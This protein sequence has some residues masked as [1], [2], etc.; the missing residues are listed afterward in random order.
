[1]GEEYGEIAPFNFFCS[2]EDPALVEAVRKGRREEFAA[3]HWQGP[4]PDPQAESTFLASKLQRELSNEGRQRTVRDFYRELIRLRKQH[5]ALS[6]LNKAAMEVTA[7]EQGKILVVRRWAGEE[8]AVSV[9][10]FADSPNT[11]QLPIPPGAWRKLLDTADVRWGGSGGRVPERIES[12]G[13]VSLE[14]DAHHAFALT[15]NETVMR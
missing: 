1:M 7:L 6:V 8:Q 15:Q 5:R 2:Y 14:V 12:S 10:S 13:S 4:L 9:F 11:C 3:F